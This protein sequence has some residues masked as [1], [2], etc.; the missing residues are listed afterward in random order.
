M[1]DANLPL[2]TTAELLAWKA[3]IEARLGLHQVSPPAPASAFSGILANAGGRPAFSTRSVVDV[4]ADHAPQAP[5]GVTVE[6]LV[7]SLPP[8]L[9]DAQSRKWATARAA[10]L[11]HGHSTATPAGV[12][13]EELVNCLPSQW[14]GNHD[15]F[16]RYLLAHPRLGP[17]LRGEGA[18]AEVARQQGGQADG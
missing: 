15:D 7:Q 18:R 16:A 3:L 1:T 10:Y 12:T 14:K 2:A 6:E 11:Q 17:L 13:V 8:N 9:R 5:Q 4:L